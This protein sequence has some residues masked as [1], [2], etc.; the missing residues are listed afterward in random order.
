[1]FYDIG[2]FCFW[3]RRS[4]VLNKAKAF[5]LTRKRCVHLHVQPYCRMEHG[6]YP[7]EKGPWK[8]GLSM[9]CGVTVTRSRQRCVSV[10][11]RDT[12][13]QEAH[14]TFA[15]GRCCMNAPSIAQG[16]TLCGKVRRGP[17]EPGRWDCGSRAGLLDSICSVVVLWGNSL[18]GNGKQM[19]WFYMSHNT[20]L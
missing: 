18:T 12:P 15:Q 5:A 19:G 8:S 4:T 10:P 16:L 3:R 7:A 1:M 17:A 14:V 13:R 11:V 6:A 9:C 20:G 2:V